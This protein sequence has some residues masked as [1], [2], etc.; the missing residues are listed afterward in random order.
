MAP[1]LRLLLALATALIAAPADAASLAAPNSSS[2]KTRLWATSSGRISDIFSDGY[3]IGNGHIGAM[4]IGG[5]PND[6]IV[7]NEDSRWSGNLLHRVNQDAAPTVREMQGLVQSGLIQQAQTLGGLSYVGTPT[8]T[9][10]YMPI[11]FMSINQNITGQTSGY[12]RWLDIADSTGG[13]YFVHDGVQYQRDFIA[14][15]PDDVIAVHLTASTTGM[16]NFN[17]HLDAGVYGSLNH[18]ADYSF[19]LPDQHAMVMGGTSE[20]GANATAWCA[21]LTIVASG[22]RVYT[23][24]DYVLVENADEA[25]V[26][27]S[28]WTSYRKSDPQA[29]VLAALSA[30][31]KRDYADVLSDHVADYRQY[32]D[33]FQLDF[34]QSTA[35]QRANTTSQRMTAISPTSFD[36]ELAALAVQYGRY[37]LIATSRNGTLPPNLQGIWN[38]DLD[39]EWGS[40][41][42]INI[43]LQM[44]YWPSLTTGK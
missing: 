34:G 19:G 29:A 1:A 30:A 39:P 13:V 8:S 42:T 20:G 18:I 28:S 25:T 14:S 43:N 31:S 32:A 12:E 2:I 17:A 21:G 16:I 7:V 38:D 5:I 35:A 4:L 15:N 44:N 22:G 36:P 41:Y 3:P 33:T 9:R 40:K 37:M 26:Y 11:G 6:L 27:F 23:Q 24:G 10:H